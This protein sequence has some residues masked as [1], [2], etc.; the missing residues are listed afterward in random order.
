[1][2][3]VVWQ[4]CIVLIGQKFPSFN[5]SEDEGTRILRNVGNYTGWSETIQ[6]GRRLTVFTAGDDFLGLCDQTVSYKHASEL[7]KDVKEY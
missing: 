5:D 4:I 2:I 3:E 7:R 6:G 1:M